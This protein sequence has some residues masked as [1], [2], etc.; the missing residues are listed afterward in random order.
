MQRLVRR[1]LG[2]SRRP[3]RALVR[4]ALRFPRATALLWVLIAAALTVGVTP[5]E[6]VVTRG[7]APFLPNSAPTVRA[8]HAM[9]TAFGSGR[10][11]SYAFVV[12]VSSHRLNAADTQ[13]YTKLVSKLR[14]NPTAVADIEDFIDQPDLRGALSSKDGKATYIPLGLSGAV[15]SAQSVQQVRWVRTQAAAVDPSA[16]TRVLVTGD[17]AMIA[18]LSDAVSHTS[19]RITLISAVLLI[20][21]LL[22][23]YRR[24]IT[25]L[26]PLATIGIAILCTRGLLAL[27]GEHGL[28]LSTYTT[29]FVMAIVLGAG[30]DYTVFL[31][32]RFREEF[33]LGRSPKEAVA[34]AGD[35]IGAALLASGATVV[36]GSICLSFTKLAIFATTGPAMAVS[37]AVTLLVSLTFT[38][39]LMTFAGARIGP[40]RVSSRRDMWARVGNL[41]ASRPAPVLVLGLVVLT[42]LALALPGI[43]LSFDERAGQPASTPSN[44]GYRALD[45]H[46]PHNTTLPDYI[47]V[48][49]DHDLRNPAD[50]AALNT[51]STAIGKVPGVANVYSITQPKGIPIS[52]ARIT[53]QL[54]D[55]ARNLNSASSKI[56]TSQPKLKRLKS[57]TADIA[58]GTKQAADG[59]QQLSNAL[60]EFTN[61]LTSLADGLGT[62]HLKTGQAV[63]GAE[64]L[65]TAA[66]TLAAGLRQAHDQVATG[67]AALNQIVQAL[68]HDLLC[69]VDPIC[70]RARGGLRLLAAGEDQLVPGLDQAATGA[71]EIASGTG[72]LADGL[73]KLNDGLATASAGASK[74][75]SGASTLE[76]NVGR[77]T[78]GLRK[79]AS[80]TGQ[81][82]P[83]VAQ[84]LK[85][86]GDLTAGIN[87]VDGYLSDVQKQASTPDAAGFYLP[88]SALR[89]PKFAAARMAF[90]SKNGRVA[91]LEIIGTTDPLTSSG[92]ARFRAVQ[93]AARQAIRKTPLAS[94]ALLATGAAGL[95]FD[96]RHYLSLDGRFVVVGVLAAVFLLLV[97][98]LGSLLAPLYLIV[99]VVLSFAAALG[100]TTLVWQDLLG[101]PI[102]FNVP[103]I[104]FVLL[105]A[106][107]A[108]Y[109]ILLMSRMREDGANLTRDVVARS[110]AATGPV[111]TAAGVIF[112]STF[113]ALIFVP[114]AGIAQSGFAVATGLILDTVVVRTLVVPAC[115]ALMGSK[116][117]W[118]SRSA[119]RRSAEVKRFGVDA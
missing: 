82:P 104:G 118:P 45:Q 63:G 18:D 106:V 96:L 94:A 114:I 22:V 64:E 56:K 5:L 20:V 12:I 87:K 47:L 59:S 15:G 97:I 6:Q 116:S 48:Q 92:L 102:E 35:R 100:L 55:L 23:I 24:I 91:R 119:R 89:D 95:G 4:S 8:L 31:I 32:S 99:S 7:S 70:N 44:Q 86:T 1:I 105:V 9:D 17:P 50:L 113:L 58:A 117:W 19:D 65:Q 84:L 54:A 14:S 21:I 13:A 111:I 79:L 108:D 115:A 76:T 98:T 75:G 101:H 52:Q 30:T 10:A 62:A 51:L 26:I 33:S 112:A 69:T 16:G 73:R 28:S 80:A 66:A 34:I 78:D 49:S 11:R 25:I 88:A 60:P 72:Q 77:L 71:T 74:L 110:V 93:T 103:V 42:L 38:P 43:H 83:G 40:A 2:R 36:L 41:V 68:N 57:G 67:T 90:L 27:M 85:Q 3:A 81:L 46:F 109:N 37:I 39:V 53:S 61:A 29:A 107:G